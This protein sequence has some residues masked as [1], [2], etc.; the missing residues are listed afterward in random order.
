MRIDTAVNRAYVLM[1]G[2]GRYREPGLSPVHPRPRHTAD[3]ETEVG[4][5]K[6]TVDELNRAT[7]T[8]EAPAQQG[9][10]LFRL[11]LPC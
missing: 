1:S 10:F 6:G 3:Q 5:A 9:P 2:A 11:Q 4:T 7:D 8:L